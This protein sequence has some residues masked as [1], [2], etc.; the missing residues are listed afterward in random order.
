MDQFKQAYGDPLTGTYTVSQKSLIVAI[1]S[2]G[3][4]FGA[5]LSG[6]LADWFGR[7]SIIIAGCFI[8]IA[9]VIV[10]TTTISIP[11]LV[12]GRLIAGLGV[13]FV[14]AVLSLIHI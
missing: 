9:G 14:T 13:G 3:T 11:A 12:V 5:L 10:Q 7:R 2:C 4:F 1:L 8:F 6:V